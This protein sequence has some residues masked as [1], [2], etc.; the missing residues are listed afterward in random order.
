[1]QRINKRTQTKQLE[2]ETNNPQN[3]KFH[4]DRQMQGPPE[5]AFAFL[6][7]LLHGCSHTATAG[8][9]TKFLRAGGTPTY[10]CSLTPLLLPRYL[11][12]IGKYASR[13]HIRWSPFWGRRRRRGRGGGGKIRW[14]GWDAV[15]NF[16][17]TYVNPL[18]QLFQ[19]KHLPL[20]SVLIQSYV[21]K[22]CRRWFYVP[23]YLV[24]VSFFILTLENVHI[25]ILWLCIM[26]MYCTIRV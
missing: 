21:R 23:R 26:D 22:E 10:L 2:T 19:V 12:K 3:L 6:H 14:D 25:Y 16:R 24:Y 5:T 9:R 15:P 8:G 13:Y 11:P 4:L 7:D 18:S 17:H 1:M 20:R